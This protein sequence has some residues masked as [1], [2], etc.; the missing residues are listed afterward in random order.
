MGNIRQACMDSEQS[1]VTILTVGT[2]AGAEVEET[3]R[4][5][6]KLSLEE[7]DALYYLRKHSKKLVVVVYAGSAVDLVEFD[8]LADAVILA[9]FGG[10]NVSQ[11]VANV[12]TGRVNPSGRLT[13]T[14]AYSVKDIPSENTKRDESVM[15]Y[16]EG[17]NVGYRYFESYGVDV[18]YP[19]GYGLSYS[20]FKYSDLKVVKKDDCV[21][22][23]LQIEN[24]SDQDGK[25]VVQ[26]YVNEVNPSVY[27][28]I[29]ELKAFEKVFIKAHEKA[30]VRFQLGKE[31][32]S[33]YSAA[34][35][36]WVVNP[37]TYLIEI[38][39]NAHEII[40]GER[41]CI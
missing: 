24:I 22:V 8:M 32:F 35:N 12:L 31:S 27:R 13:E 10:Q 9:G 39:K 6:I 30:E 4:R 29:R 25:E 20:D 36:E 2:R 15:V 28:P 38:R 16:E 5:D 41:V 17:L 3:D 19:F 34:I 40:M 11:A 21:E 14:Y 37:G 33:Y 7:L 1:D 18:L 23:T 26:L